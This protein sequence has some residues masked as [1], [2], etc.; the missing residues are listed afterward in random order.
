MR[1]LFIGA[2]LFSIIAPS[3]RADGIGSG[4]IVREN[5]YI[6]TNHHVI[7]NAKE[8]W[9]VVPG[10]P[11]EMRATV[12]M[13]DSLHD[14][15]LLK[16]RDNNDYDVLHVVSSDVASV[17]DDVFVFGYP[18]EPI[19]G[20]GVSAS[21]GQIN[22]LRPGFL[23]IDATVN[24]GNSGGPVLNDRGEVIGVVVSRVSAMYVLK[25]VSTHGVVRRRIYRLT[26]NGSIP[27]VI[28]INRS[29]KRL[30]PKS[31]PGVCIMPIVAWELFAT[32]PSF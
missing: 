18:L 11:T 12:M 29:R 28:F 15:A 9:V 31:V 5:G 2:I 19:L 13:D 14:L 10:R 17:M 23:Q 32:A 25:S 8:I 27:T 4:F 6:V 30:R 1:Q 20:D 3:L 24:P 22:A 16:I 21:H 26:V 7:E